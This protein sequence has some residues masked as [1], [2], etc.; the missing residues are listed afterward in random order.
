MRHGSW[1]K[2]LWRICWMNEWMDGWMYG[3]VNEWIHVLIPFGMGLK[4]KG[5]I[6]EH[7]HG[8]SAGR[9]V[10]LTRVDSSPGD[11]L[12]EEQLKDAAPRT[13]QERVCREVDGQTRHPRVGGWALGFLNYGSWPHIQ[14]SYNWMWGPGK[15][16]NSKKF[17]HTQWLKVQNQM[18][19]GVSGNTRRCY[20]VWLHCSIGSGHTPH[21]IVLLVLHEWVYQ[22]WESERTNSE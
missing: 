20:V 4:V 22:A 10:S 19:E 17:L 1:I 11:V 18:H 12:L 14:W 5:F 8:H 7:L 6:P 15:S 2:D 16:G 9:K 21:V 13:W 3:R